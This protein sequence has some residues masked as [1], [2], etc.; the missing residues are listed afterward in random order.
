MLSRYPTGL[1]SLNYYQDLLSASAM[2]DIECVR[3]LYSMQ[4][5]YFYTDSV[6][7]SNYNEVW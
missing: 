2:N 7:F 6:H 1:L 3:A 5:R 4:V